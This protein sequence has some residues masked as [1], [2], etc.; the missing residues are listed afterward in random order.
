[1]YTD[2]Y[3]LPE[4]S[5][6]STDSQD[7]SS[8]FMHADMYHMAL[9]YEMTELRDLALQRFKRSEANI[10]IDQFLHMGKVIYQNAESNC[11]L[12]QELVLK[13]V[14]KHAAWLTDMRFRLVH[15]CECLV[16]VWGSYVC[17]QALLQIIG[18]S[19]LMPGSKR[20]IAIHYD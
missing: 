19:V 3:L 6:F 14:N 10:T 9:F 1:M 13:L 2:D 17:Q 8:L 20:L 5:G 18:M 16:A 4:S 11:D 15:Y 12:R 7:A